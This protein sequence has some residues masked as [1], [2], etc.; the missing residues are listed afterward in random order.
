MAFGKGGSGMAG[1]Y[2]DLGLLLI[3]LGIGGSVLVLH[4]W[5]KITAGPALWAKL[6]AAMGHLGIHFLP[7][8]WGF[9]ASLAESLGSTLLILGVFFRP[10]AACLAFNMFVAALVHLNMPAGAANAGWS[11]ASHALELCAVYLGLFFIGPGKFSLAPRW[12]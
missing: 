10:A 11:G 3:R 7:V 5:T 2:G 6:G 8:F 12:K 4:G 1:R 9:M